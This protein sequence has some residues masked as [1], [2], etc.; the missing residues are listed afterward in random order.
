[1]KVRE[2]GMPEAELWDTFF[3]PARVLTLLDFTN[4][5]AD[6]VEFGC[7]YG[8]FT[9]PAA[10]RTRGTVYALDIE[11]KMIRTTAGK[12]QSARLRNVRT[13]LQDFVAAG[14]GLADAS[15]GYAML[16]NILH[17]RRPA[18]L[19]EEAFPCWLPAAGSGSCTGFT[20]PQRHGTGFKDSASTG[21]VPGL[22][23][24]G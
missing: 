14:T 12:V 3:D 9:V 11:P 13:I 6:V 4:A 5:K 22:A 19:L 1:M 24:P 7:G 17:A 23:A 2:S 10:R 18:G 20:I 21:A 8:T 15:V 16:F